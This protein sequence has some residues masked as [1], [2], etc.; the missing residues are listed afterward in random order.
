MVT[1][2]LHR[3]RRF[4]AAYR[5]LSGWR[6]FLLL[7]FLGGFSVLGHAPFFAWP[8]YAV[9]LSALVLALDDAKSR[10]RP[11][12]SGFIRG[13]WFASGAFLAGTGWVANAF[14][15]SAEDYAW[16]RPLGPSR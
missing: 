11:L 2:L 12:R 16:L 7:F 3:A 4:R 8:A 14:L 10:Q 15:V 9:G 13:F 5:A 1:G 6:L